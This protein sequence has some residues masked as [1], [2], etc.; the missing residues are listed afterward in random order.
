MCPAI[1]EVDELLIRAIRE[2][3][4]PGTPSRIGEIGRASDLCLPG[5]LI[6]VLAQKCERRLAG[7]QKAKT[8]TTRLV[9]P[10]LYMHRDCVQ[11][12]E[13]GQSR[14]QFRLLDE[15]FQMLS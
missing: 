4:I 14:T 15:M 10:A 5:L 8:A 3:P 13:M 1:D 6:S 12:G 11:G 7:P 9:F 2:H